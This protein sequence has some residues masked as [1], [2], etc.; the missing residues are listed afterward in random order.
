MVH[1][2]G[3]TVSLICLAHHFARALA[4]LPSRFVPFARTSQDGQRPGIST[5]RGQRHDMISRDPKL[6]RYCSED[7]SRIENYDTAMND[8]EQMWHCHHRAEIL[9]CG[10]Y[11]IKELKAVGLYWHRPASELIFLR[12][13]EHTRLHKTGN[14]NFLGKSHSDETKR[15]IAEKKRGKHPSLEARRKMS[16]SQTNHPD[17][18]SPVEMTRI[19][20]GFTKVFPS[21]QEAARWLREN[22]FPKA[23][24]TTISLCVNERRATTYNAT[25]RRV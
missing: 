1:L 13:D 2:G 14:K 7:L 20:D 25:W 5:K 4:V 11:S 10:R 23:T 22:G 8:K 12:P 15:R 16:A 21:Q 6:R 19:S 9:P 18:S 24:Q 17:T 3:G